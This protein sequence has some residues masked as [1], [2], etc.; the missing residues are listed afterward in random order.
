MK[1]IAIVI[2]ILIAAGAIAGFAAYVSISKSLHALSQKEIGITDL[3]IVPDG[4]YQGRYDSVP[5][6]VLVKIEIRDHRILDIKIQEHQNGKGTAAETIIEKI[7]A[8]Q[9]IDVD[10]IGGATY[11]SKAIAL[12]VKDAIQ[13]N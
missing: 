12:A 7:I 1:K 10:G 11:S 6:K 8:E 3:S 4:V 13:G 2:G 5:I 9:R